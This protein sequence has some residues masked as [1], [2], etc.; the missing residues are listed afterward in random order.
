MAIVGNV[1]GGVSLDG[2]FT[3]GDERS[4]RYVSN[5]AIKTVA[6]AIDAQDSLVVDRGVARPCRSCRE[7]E[8]ADG[9]RR[10][11]RLGQELRH[12]RHCDSFVVELTGGD[13]HLAQKVTQRD[14]LGAKLIHHGEK[15]LVRRLPHHAAQTVAQS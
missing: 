5:R 8:G 4:A 2:Y 7:H 12:R 11:H 15:R 9:F 13:D 1:R 10:G 14:R 6:R 3:G